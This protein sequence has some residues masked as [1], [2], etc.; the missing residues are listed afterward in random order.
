MLCCDIAAGLFSGLK[1]DVENWRCYLIRPVTFASSF[2]TPATAARR[3]ADRRE[4]HSQAE[5]AGGSG[6][7]PRGA[8]SDARTRVLIS[9]R[10][11]KQAGTG[12]VTPPLRLVAPV[13]GLLQAVEVSA[14]RGEDGCTVGAPHIA[15]ERVGAD[16]AVAR[17]FGDRA[18][19]PAE[20]AVVHG[21]PA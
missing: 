2:E 11:R 15:D 5:A 1:P 10:T 13:A 14:Q 12:G 20:D 16:E 21:T 8:K 3:R 6:R 17:V 4:G 18:D 19:D 9:P 7:P